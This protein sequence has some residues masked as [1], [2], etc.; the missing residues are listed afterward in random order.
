LVNIRTNA[1]ELAK[2]RKLKNVAVLPTTNSPE[3]V[4]AKYLWNLD[5]NSDVW[6][7]VD[8]NFN[9]SYCFRDYS[10]TEIEA[11][12]VKAKI[13]FNSHI[14]QWGPNASRIINPWAKANKIE[15]DK[16]LK[17]F[18]DTYNKFAKELSIKSL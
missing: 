10:L 16:F 1:K 8:P 18:A 3:R 13:W 14:K 9:K 6:E 7:S 4:L 12:R 2:I 15:V 17:E 5:D 11:D